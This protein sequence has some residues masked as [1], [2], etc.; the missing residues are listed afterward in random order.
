MIQLSETFPTLDCSQCI[1]TPKMVEI[2]KHSNV[3]L[4]TYSE[5][6]E[7]S[8]YVGNFKVKILKKP[9]YIIEDKCNLCNKCAEACPVAVPNEFNRG[10]S[11]RRAI[12]IPFPQAIPATYT[13]DAESCISCGKCAKVCEAE[14]IIL[15][16]TPCYINIGS[17][18]VSHISS[19][20]MFDPEEKGMKNLSKGQ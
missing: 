9:R 18:M 19:I 20:W 15:L 16:S 2:W 4:L 8:G 17:L 11:L 3:R 6:L 1:L 14:A 12:Y 10:L 7:V 13:L 5:V